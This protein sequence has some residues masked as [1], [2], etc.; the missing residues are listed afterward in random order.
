[1]KLLLILLLF[2]FC[3]SAKDLYQI[4]QLSEQQIQ[5]T[6]LRLLEDACQFADRDWTNSSFDPSAGYWGDG[7]S[8]GNEGIRT[9]S[10]MVLACG[11]LLKYDDSLNSRE[12][13]N[14]LSKSL[15]AIRYAT[16]THFTGTQ[17]C[18]NGKQWGGLDRPGSKAWQSSYWA[19]SL[20]FGAW[21][22]W[23]KLDPESRQDVERVVTAQDDLLATGNPPVNLWADTKAEEN[24]WNVPLLCLGELMFPS[25]SHA[26]LWHATALK[27]M[28]NTLCTAADLSDTNLVDGRA[29]RDW[30]RG[31]NLQPDYTLENHGFFHPSYVGCSSYFLTQAALYYAYGGKTVPETASHHLMDTWRMFRT[32]ILPWGETA[33]PQSM[34]WELH[35]LPVIDLYG[36]LATRDK[37]PFAARMEQSSLQYLR[38]WQVRYHGNLTLPGSP[39]GVARHAINAELIS[40]GFL[41]HKIFGPSTTPL[42]ARAAN[43]QEQGVWNYPYVD[44]IEHRTLQKFASFSW[45]NRIMGLLMPI[46]DHESNPEFIVPIMNGFIGS[47]Q[48]AGRGN[49]TTV[50]VVEHSRKETPDGF[51]TSGTVLLNGGR[52]RQ[53]LTMISIGNQTVIYE[54][55]VTALTNVIIRSER[56]IPIGIENDDITG[57]TRTVFDQDGKIKFDW[58]KPRPLL[59]L[60]GSCANVDGRLGIIVLDGAGIAYAQS[61]KYS[62]GIAVRTDILY[63]SFSN[64][65]RQF[66]AGDEVARRIA[67]FFV[68]VTPQETSEL[69]KYCRIETTPDSR[70]LHFRQPNGNDTSVP[71]F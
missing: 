65:A 67:I 42:T 5:Q 47:F 34:D 64:Q 15:A 18:T 33:C 29:V 63:G 7:V 32:I 58:Q 52:L 41:A 16:A 38:A 21:L 1:M 40:Y 71:L 31:A 23:D 61:A 46:D 30:V 60:A 57:G 4:H 35:A 10:S 17:K 66:K 6:Y 36:T 50:A 27:Y 53:T 12:R 54:D 2:P 20:A 39:L 19:G 62:P 28:M 55:R 56:G 13:R 44:F 45:K 14:L 59:T 8:S 3:A 51:E 70:N 37:D 26:D 22:I 25:N 11:T 24:G 49:N 48:V 43:A 68:E 9:V 69:A